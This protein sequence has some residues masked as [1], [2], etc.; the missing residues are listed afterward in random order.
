M[1]QRFLFNIQM[2]PY[3]RTVCK[4][5]LMKFCFALIA[6]CFL[7][8]AGFSQTKT[9]RINLYI[10]P[11]DGSAPVLMDGTLSFY[12]NSYSDA[13]DRMDARKMFNPGENWGML[14]DG[15]VLVVERRQDIGAQD[16]IFFKFWNSRIITYRIQFI[17]SYFYGSGISAKMIDKYLN[18]VTPISLDQKDSVTNID[19][20][21]FQITADP[22]SQ[23]TDRFM[24]VFSGPAVAGVLPLNFVKT[25]AQFNKDKVAIRWETADESNVAN[26]TIERSSDG[27]AFESTGLI[28]AAKNQSSCQYVA[29]DLHPL[30][31]TGYY[32]IR[33]TDRDGRE[34]FSSVMKVTAPVAL[35]NVSLIPNPTT[36]SDIRV[37]INSQTS[38]KYNF[39][40]YREGGRLLTS[41][42]ENIAIGTTD[43]KLNPNQPLPAGIY[44]VEIT[45]PDGFRQT[46]NL[47]IR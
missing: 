19:S 34:K 43:I 28:I 32:R 6:L 44:R 17:S 31:G 3:G 5:N 46:L 7:S 15:Y 18:K 26:Y 10:V 4:I 12:D 36:A 41:Q 24:L 30:P 45:G 25:S 39:N 47:L 1:W 35:A 2:D 33:A 22:A 42:I 20:L 40:L 11:P 27:T 13:V 38:G 21:D 14:R 8:S 9:F 16:T 37:R 23:R 29:T